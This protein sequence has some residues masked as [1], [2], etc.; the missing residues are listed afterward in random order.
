MTPLGATID[1]EEEKIKGRTGETTKITGHPGKLLDLSE[2]ELSL[3]H[4]TQRGHC[5]GANVL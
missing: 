3:K 5:L 4:P 1:G 2:A